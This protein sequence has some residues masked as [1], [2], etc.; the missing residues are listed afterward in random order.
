MGALP[1]TT[2]ALR[3]VAP[4]TFDRCEVVR[5]D[6]MG[7]DEVE[8]ELLA[9]G[10]CGS[11]L[12]KF[13]R[14]PVGD[15]CLPGFPIHECVGV[16]RRGPVK[17]LKG[18][19]VLAIPTDDRGLMGLYT[20]S[21]DQC[22]RLA[23]RWASDRSALSV[24]TLVQ[25][26]ATVLFAADRYGDACG[27]TVAVVGAGPIGLLHGLVAKERG[28]RQVVGVDPRVVAEDVTVFGFDDIVTD[29]DALPRSTFDLCIEA[30]GD[31]DR[32]LVTTIRLC[33][34]DGRVLAFG[35]PSESEYRVPFL[36]L[37]RKRLTL[38]V[39]VDTPWAHY[40][41]AAEAF[42][43]RHYDAVSAVV[44]HMLPIDQAQHGFELAAS[45]EP[46][47]RKVVLLA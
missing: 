6:R 32:T 34:K 30:V 12:P 4:S 13:K 36:E 2:W 10:I 42:I 44:S 24:A 45:Q 8:V 25:P 21:R 27:N 40:M 33:R 23:A 14:G 17:D 22:H 18:Q 3:L 31:Q 7:I 46:Y 26:L 38:L 28:A 9:A 47:R 37:F 5:P 43:Q 35:V 20:A 41:A 39:A 29:E 19:L 16:V 15:N 11:D 1:S